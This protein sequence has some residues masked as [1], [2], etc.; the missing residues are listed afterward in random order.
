MESRYY[1][2]NIRVFYRERTEIIFNSKHI[3]YLLNFFQTFK[4]YTDC[5][6]LN[7]PIFV[8]LLEYNSDCPLPETKGRNDLEK[9]DHYI[10]KFVLIIYRIPNRW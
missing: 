6:I 7:I 5:F 3:T 2:C 1:E 4:F 8:F 10:L 9:F